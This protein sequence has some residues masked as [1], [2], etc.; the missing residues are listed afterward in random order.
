DLPQ[1]EPLPSPGHS[2]QQRLTGSQRLRG[3]RE[4]SIDA[5]LLEN[6]RKIRSSRILVREQS[7]GIRPAV[8]SRVLARRLLRRTGTDPDLSSPRWFS[9]SEGCEAT[10]N[11]KRVW[12]VESR[13]V[14][15]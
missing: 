14:C 3:A 1:H 15:D 12:D 9:K 6:R 10:R 7:K 5:F 8:A 13:K 4:L 11:A 2:F